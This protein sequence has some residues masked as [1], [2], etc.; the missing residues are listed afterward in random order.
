MTYDF[1]SPEERLALRQNN[2]FEMGSIYLIES[3]FPNGNREDRSDL[4]I[5]LKK[6]K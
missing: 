1:I 2:S 5:I 6:D 4:E 3:H